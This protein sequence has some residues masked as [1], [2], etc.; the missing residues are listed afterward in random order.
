MFHFFFLITES[1]VPP[2]GFDPEG[3]S[4]G[5][6][7]CASNDDSGSA[8]PNFLKWAESLHLL[9]ND[10]TGL[11]LFQEYLEQE[12]PDRFHMLKFWLACRGVPKQPSQDTAQYIK[13]IYK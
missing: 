5:D 11:E 13:V 4:S 9:L 7:A 12:D 10:P 6:A 2:S 1:N 8:S 3:R